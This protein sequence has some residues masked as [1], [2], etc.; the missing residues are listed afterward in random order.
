MTDLD[1]SVRRA[2]IDVVNQVGQE[3]DYVIIVH[4]HTTAEKGVIFSYEF[5]W[6]PSD[7]GTDGGGVLESGLVDSGPRQ[8][9]VREV[10]VRSDEPGTEADPGC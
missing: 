8:E 5:Y 2:L 7:T 6:K 4:G 9:Q 10:P 1:D 3:G